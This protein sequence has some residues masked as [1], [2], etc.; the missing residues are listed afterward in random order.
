MVRVVAHPGYIVNFEF[1][2]ECDFG[3]GLIAVKSYEF[4]NLLVQHLLVFRG[5]LQ[6]VLWEHVMD[7]FREEIGDLLVVGCT[8]FEKFLEDRASL[9]RIFCQIFELLFSVVPIWW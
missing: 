6:E 4:N 9:F 5:T 1:I 2:Q 3:E 7:V 8:I